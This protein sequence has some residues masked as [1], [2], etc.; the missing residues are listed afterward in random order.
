LIEFEESIRQTEREIKT[1]T[2]ENFKLNTEARLV[3]D[4][5]QDLVK[6]RTKLD[7]SYKEAERKIKRDMD[8]KKNC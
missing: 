4:E 7:F 8:Q 3:D 5:K 6:E 2:T 1:L